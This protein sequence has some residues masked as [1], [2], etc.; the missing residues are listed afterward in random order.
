MFP[1]LVPL[2]LPIT[3]VIIII[4]FL[5]FS[6]VCLFQVMTRLT[7]ISVIFSFKENDSQH[8]VFLLKIAL[9]GSLYTILAVAIERFLS[10]SRF[11]SPW[12]MKSKF[13]NKFGVN[14]EYI[15]SMKSKFLQVFSQD[16]H[17]WCCNFWSRSYFPFCYM[18]ALFQLTLC[19]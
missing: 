10:I 3:Q 14:L 18:Y 19:A 17:C 12:S 6:S 16:T 9:T 8:N 15:W 4:A 1:L 2:L 11:D 7:Y 13:W 5:G